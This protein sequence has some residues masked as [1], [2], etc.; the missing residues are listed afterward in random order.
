MLM[1]KR[2]IFLLSTS[3]YSHKDNLSNI[4]GFAG[5][6]T[7]SQLLSSTKVTKIPKQNIHG[8]GKIVFLNL[9]PKRSWI[10]KFFST[11]NFFFFFFYASPFKN[12][13][14]C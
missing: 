4:L 14:E 3:V 13:K 12:E 2:H 1:S 8:V 10:S 5:C 11:I 6:K 7:S 9:K